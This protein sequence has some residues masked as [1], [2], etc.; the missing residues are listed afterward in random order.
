MFSFREFL[1]EGYD[2]KSLKKRKVPLT[3]EEREE[4]L[5][6]KAVWNFS[7]LDKPTPAVWHSKDSKG[8]DVYVTNTHRAFNTAPTL[9]GAIDRYHKFIKGTA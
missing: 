1:S 6:K 4:C 7:H 9:A 3:K 2:F 5:K 8:K